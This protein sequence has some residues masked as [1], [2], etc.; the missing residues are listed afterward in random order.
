MDLDA[1]LNADAERARVAAH[2]AAGERAARTPGLANLD[3][4]RALLRTLVLDELEDYHRRGVFPKNRDFPG[5]RVPYFIDADGTRCAIAHLMEQSGAPSLVSRVAAE[6]NHAL[7]PA[8][9]DIQGVLAWLDA[10][11]ISVSEAARIQ[12]T[13]GCYRAAR[14]VCEGFS[15]STFYK[16]PVEYV[17]EVCVAS[18][19]VADAGALGTAL[20]PVSAVYGISTRYHA[21]DVIAVPAFLAR[22]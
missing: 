12:P 16:T 14:T 18:Q 10:V 11:G 17:L 1:D 8:M 9:A 13:Y 3:P 6:R 15:R 20:V 4:L 21:G 7:V 5:E 22:E 19:N 2:V